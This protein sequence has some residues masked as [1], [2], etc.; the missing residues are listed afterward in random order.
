MTEETSKNLIYN[1]NAIWGRKEDLCK[2]KKTSPQKSK[3]Y[4]DD[5]FPQT[6]ID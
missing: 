2:T 1:S 6:H 4:P 5:A 3:A